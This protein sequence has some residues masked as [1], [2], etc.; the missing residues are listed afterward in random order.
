MLSAQADSAWQGETELMIYQCY[1]APEQK[2]NLFNS[3][4]YCGFGLEPEVNPRITG[5]YPELEDPAVR[6]ALSEYAAFLYL[7]RNPPCDGDNWIGFTSYRQS[8]KTPFVFRSKQQVR[9]A[10]WLHDAAG[11]GF[12]KVSRLRAEPWCGAAAQSEKAHPGIMKF[13]EILAGEFD[14]ELP[15]RFF[16]DRY[17]L[18]A[19][20]WVMRKTLF[21]RYMEWSWPK[22][23]WC[24]EHRNDY[25]YLRNPLSEQADSFECPGFSGK[26]RN[27]GCVME[28]LFIV[29][30]MDQNLKIRVLGPCSRV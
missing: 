2:R 16:T 28:R 15:Q 20:Y 22:I 21:T 29:W 5:N 24:L 4:V 18:Y 23:R 13:L 6:L 25:D 27:I 10:L 8:A 3:A 30:Y 19:N 17:I 26:R 1:F 11:W 9:R 12:R 7:W 14:F